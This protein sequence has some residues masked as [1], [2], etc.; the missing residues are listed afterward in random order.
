MKMNMTITLKSQIET[1]KMVRKPSPGVQRA[2][3]SKKNYK[4]PQGN[5]WSKWAN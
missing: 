4:R 2:I 1:M 5:N 3:P